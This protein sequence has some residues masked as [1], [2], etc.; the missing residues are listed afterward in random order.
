MMPS[1]TYLERLFEDLLKTLRKDF[2]KTFHMLW[3]FCRRHCGLV[4]V[5]KVF[6][7][8]FKGPSNGF[9]RTLKLLAGLL[10]TSLWYVETWILKLF[11]GPLKEGFSTTLQKLFQGVSKSLKR[12]LNSLRRH[13]VRLW[14]AFQMFL[15]S[16]SGAWLKAFQRRRPR[17]GAGKFAR[18]AWSALP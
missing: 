4:N 9:S 11:Q 15:E 10:K 13:F 1:H 8:G 14:E 16:L 17:W 3:K 12:R 6:E 7:R 2:W 5:W 18:T